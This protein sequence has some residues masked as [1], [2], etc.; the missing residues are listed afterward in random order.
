VIHH[1]L[2]EWP[3]LLWGFF[4]GL[5][6]ASS[7]VLYR[8]LPRRGL[9]EA[10]AGLLGIVVAAAIGFATPASLEP[11]PYYIFGAGMVAICAM[12][13]PGISGSFLLLLMGLYEVIIAAIKGLD[14]G[15]LA[16]F[17]GGCAI[18]LLA[19]SHVVAYFLARYESVTL[20]T[21]TGFMLGALVKVWPW[22]HATSFRVNSKG[23][24]VPLL[25]HP[26]LPNT[27]AELTG[28]PN[29]ALGVIVCGLLGLAVV[30]GFEYFSK[31]KP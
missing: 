13:L 29:W 4:F 1:L 14:L 22:Q 21:L 18:G 9:F 23:E 27:Y 8:H 31:Q 28:E 6:I 17:A 2:A 19:F 25:Q 30:F 20:A 7:I 24:T 12:I 3:Q 15:V 5:I 16:L 26:V 11:A 10:V